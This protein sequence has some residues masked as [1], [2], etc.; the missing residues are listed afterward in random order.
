MVTGKH[1]AL[2][3]VMILYLMILSNLTAADSDK[4]IGYKIMTM[5]TAANIDALHLRRIR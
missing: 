5:E 3:M 2:S 4:I 1:V